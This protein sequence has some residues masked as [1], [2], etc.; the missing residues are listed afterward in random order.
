MSV[1]DL[2]QVEIIF[3]FAALVRVSCLL[4]LLPIFSH[5]AIPAPAKILFCFTLTLILF[6][7][8]KARGFVNPGQIQ[9]DLGII[10]L[11]LKEA[12]VGFVLGFIAKTFFDAISFAFSFMAMQMGFSMAAQYDPHLESS[13]PVVAQFILILASLLLLASDTHH[14]MLQGLDQ[15]FQVIPIGA[16]IATKALV[17]FVMETANQIFLIAIK[18][19]A[20]MALVIFLVN[21]AFGIIAKA[22]PQINVLVVSLSVNALAG[23]FVLVLVLPIFGS[24]MNE[25]FADMIGH[26]MEATRY[27]HG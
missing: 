24:S 13:T 22:V 21:L 19:S 10:L 18:V 14:M 7:M 25:V 27:L 9:S 6:P 4:L 26:M 1:Y 11:V 3:F 20:P 16:G 17:A 12:M 2:N 5:I 23:F 15:S 8:A